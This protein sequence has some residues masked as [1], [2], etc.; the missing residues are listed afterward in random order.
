[1][2]GME[3]GGVRWGLVGSDGYAALGLRR[4]GVRLMARP[5]DWDCYKCT[6][7]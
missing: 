4:G 3:W 1:M 5:Y 6:A 2:H 7:V